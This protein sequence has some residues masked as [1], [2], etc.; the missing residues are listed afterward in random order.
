MFDSSSIENLPQEVDVLRRE[1]D[2]LRTECQRLRAELQTYQHEYAAK[3]DGTYTY[4]TFIRSVT[5]ARKGIVYAACTDYVRACTMS[6]GI[7]LVTLDQLQDF[8]RHDKVPAYVVEQIPQL[9]FPTRHNGLPHPIWT[10]LEKE[11]LI[12]L[13]GEHVSVHEIA[14][15]CTTRFGRTITVGSIKGMMDRLGLNSARVIYEG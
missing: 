4:L 2:D 6:E 3:P 14:D 9:H 5:R 11:Y 1:L 15:R 10:P 13:V 12:G 7:Q 8:K